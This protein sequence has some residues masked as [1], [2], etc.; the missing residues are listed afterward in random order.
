MSRSQLI[1]L[2]LVF[3]AHGGDARRAE[4]LRRSMLAAAASAG[5]ALDSRHR[6]SIR[7]DARK[8]AAEAERIYSERASDRT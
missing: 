4:R 3:A 8:V 7:A 2:S 1:T 5:S 6:R